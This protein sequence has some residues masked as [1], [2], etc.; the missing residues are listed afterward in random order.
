MKFFSRKLLIFFLFLLKTIDCGY[1]LEYPSFGIRKLDIRGYSLHRHDYVMVIYSGCKC[2]E[3]ECGLLAFLVCEVYLL[4]MCILN[5]ENRN[6]IYV[7]GKI[8][9]DIY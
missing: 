1:A 2:I 3:N 4:K 9:Q 6:F 8:Q 5:L 7:R